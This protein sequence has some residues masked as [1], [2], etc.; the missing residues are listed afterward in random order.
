MLPICRPSPLSLVLALQAAI[1]S[2]AFAAS[3]SIDTSSTE[4][5]TLNAGESG[6]IASGGTLSVADNTVAVAVR[7]GTSTLVNAGELR[8][9]G[10]ARAIDA[11]NGNPLFTLHNRAGATIDA[12]GNV[13]I[14][15][16]RTGGQYLIDNQG[17]ISQSGQT[18]G[19]ERAIKA[20]GEYTSTGN[21]IINGAQNNRDAVISSVG[22]DALRL[23]SNFTLT[24]YGRIF[25]TGTVNTSCPG[26]ISSQCSNDYSAADGVAIENQRANVAIINHGSIEGPRHGIDGGAPLSAEADA[27]LFGLQRLVIRSAT[28]AG[29]TFDR[30]ANGVTTENVQI[31]NPVIINQADG[32]VIGRNGS[33]IGL[34]G[35]GVVFNYGLVSGRYAGAGNIYDHE[36]L[37]VTIANGDGDGVDIDGI[38]YIENHGRIEGLGAGGLDSGGRPNGG[39]GIAAGGG[40]IRNL[41][42]ASIFGQSA[43]I[44]IDDGAN[45]SEHP[46]GRGTLGDKAANGG[47]AYIVNAGDITGADKVG[48][49]L[50]GRYDDVLI[51]EASG[52]IRGGLQTVRVDELNSATAAAAVQMGAGNDT[53]VNAG[54]IE[55]RNGLAVDLGDGDDNLT[56]RSTARFIGVVDGGAGTDSVTL[57]DA[58]GGS[59]ANSRNFENLDVR[60]GAWRLDSDDFSASTRIYSGASLLNLG[61]LQGDVRVD[62]GATFGGGRVGGNLGLASGSTLALAV[63]PGGTSNALQVGGTV[64]LNGARLRIDALAGDYPLQSRYQVLQA[65][66]AITGTFADFS[67][68]LAFLTPTLHYTDHSVDVN[69]TR[70]DRRFA[71]L[72]RNANGRG[73]AGA[74]QSQGGGTLYNA[75]LSSSSDQAA[76]A[77]DQLSASSNA[78]LMTASLAGS[79]QV[80]NSMLGAMQQT[81]GSANLQ[82]SLLRDDAPL[83]ASSGVPRQ[84][85]NLNS[86]GAEGRLWLQGIGSHGKLDGSNGAD[87]LTQDTRGA[88]LGADWAVDSAWR[89][90]VLGGYAGTDVDAGRGAS[91]DINSLHLGVYALRQS[92]ALALRLGAAYSRHDNSSKRQVDF[93]GFSDRLRGD[94]HANSQQ[95]FAELGYQLA[96][97][98]LLAEPFAAIGYQR[99]SH[100]SYDEKGGAA[101]LH[102]DSHE[103]DNLNSTL[104][105]RVAHLGTLGNGMSL[106]PRASLGW[107]HTYGELGSQAR[108]SFLSGGNAFSVEGTTLD[109]DTLLADAGLDL[110]I[111]SAQSLGLGYN[112]EYGS[113]TQNHAL[114]AQW[115]LRF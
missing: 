32:T 5:Q 63:S 35:H 69:L 81:S 25:S 57:D 89:V 6:S 12:V 23:G 79:A 39:D 101:A 42:G 90:G 68:S 17:T 76:S 59:F 91:S 65:K 10:S 7:G 74:L 56:L 45:G 36:G 58:A 95:A 110:G 13:A 50:V 14:R 105:L 80:G 38:A 84:A 83:L 18:I 112:G 71:D 60:S 86:P 111:S 21:Q 97:G 94:Y 102:V 27:N 52:V 47:V 34:D 85:R 19:G 78:S 30:I 51:N 48:V 88:V 67:S 100:Q 93:A 75:V 9:T 70:N 66:G 108:Q 46:S 49:G 96:S 53:L 15:L 64:A 114:V 20:D 43:G 104:G 11:N 1:A 33:G 109:R 82:A 41:A 28:G 16:N 4:G 61:T 55:G 115:Q 24:N 99:Y 54:L 98:R 72:A 3:F 113:R 26:Y 8:Q 107:R 40:T 92:G 31:A 77:F 29:V 106:T 87:D 37:G 2:P 62:S 44:L 103:Q 73:A 22:N